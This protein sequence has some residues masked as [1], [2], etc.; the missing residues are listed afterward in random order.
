LTCHRLF[1]G[2]AT[3]KVKFPSKRGARL[4]DI[5]VKLT[6]NAADLRALISSELDI[7]D[8]HRLKLISGGRVLDAERNLR[9][10]NVKNFQQI[11]VL[12]INIDREQASSESEPYDRIQKIR[13][14]AEV[15]LKNKNSN[16]FNVSPLHYCV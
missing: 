6:E 1:I 15:L 12:E 4:F 7:G 2:L 8:I 9:D 11:L 16:Y 10:Q 5:K 3:L 13:K 14:D